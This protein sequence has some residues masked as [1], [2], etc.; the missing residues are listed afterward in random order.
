MIPD[1]STV[2]LALVVAALTMA[3]SPALGQR[4]DGSSGAA[5][6]GAALGAMSGSMLALAGGLGAC[7]RTL[8]PTR[9][10]RITTLTGAA[11]GLSAGVVIGLRNESGLDDRLENSGMGAA[12][13]A[14][15]GIVL[16]E[17]VYEYGWPDVA[18]TSVLGLAI[19]ASAEGAGLG[20]AAGTVTGLLLWRLHPSVG[21]AGAVMWAL[22]GLAVGGLGDWVADDVG[23][24]SVMTAIPLY[25]SVRR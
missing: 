5:L 24:D 16:K 12:V 10:S 18:A 22:A 14:V 11:I 7:N 21:P 3:P 8:D 1:R 4:G 19:G 20:F 23:G 13:G 15:A 6:G 25:F 2:A 9:C 17:F